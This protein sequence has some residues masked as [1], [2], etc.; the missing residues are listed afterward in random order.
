LAAVIAQHSPAVRAFEKRVI[1][2]LFRGSTS[3]GFTLV[4]ADSN[5]VSN[6]HI[7]S[8]NCDLSFG[9][10]K[11]T[12]TGREADE[13]GATTAVPGVPSREAAGSSTESISNCGTIDPKIMR[14][15]G[16]A[17]CFETAQ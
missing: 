11:P 5:R 6:V 15:G 2:R 1:V 9:S 16:G 13:L 8:R 17:D 7:T 12:L 4:D 14:A 10:R 3:F